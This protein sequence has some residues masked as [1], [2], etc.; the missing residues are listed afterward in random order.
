[1]FIVPFFTVVA[2]SLKKEE[3]NENWAWIERNLMT[4]LATFDKDED[5]TDF[6]RCKIESLVANS[7]VA[8]PHNT[9]GTVHY[10]HF[11]FFFL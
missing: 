1:M 8:D 4:I 6:V 11:D 5:V 2:V 9:P 10:C 7:T 3:I